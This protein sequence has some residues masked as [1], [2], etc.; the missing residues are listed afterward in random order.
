MRKRRVKKSSLPKRTKRVYISF[1]SSFFTPKSLSVWFL[2]DKSK[3]QTNLDY[4]Y[5]SLNNKIFCSDNRSIFVD[6]AFD[7]TNHEIFLNK[8]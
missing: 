2:K 6:K 5:S 1:Y 8:L 4:F 7:T 3:A